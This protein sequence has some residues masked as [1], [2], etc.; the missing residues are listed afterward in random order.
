MRT[1]T[2]HSEN[3]INFTQN[4]ERICFA[5]NCYKKLFPSHTFKEMA[6]VFGLSH[7][8]ARRYYYGMHHFNPGCQGTC[9]N[10][11]REGAHVPI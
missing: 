1:V 4:A 9:Y 6:Q 7:T 11:M 8:N 3:S 2:V 10:Q 5:L